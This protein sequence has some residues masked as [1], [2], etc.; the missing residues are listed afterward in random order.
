MKHS[1]RARVIVRVSARNIVLNLI[2]AALKI[3]AG[4]LASSVA[5]LSDG[6][7]SLADV[8]TTLVVLISNRFTSAEKDAEHQYGHEKIESLLTMF[9]AL[10]LCVGAVV[11]AWE[12]VARLIAREQ[13]SFSWFALGA[14]L[15]SAGVKYYLH[16]ATA[17]AARQLDSDAL[18]L[19]AEDYKFDVLLSA[20]VFAGVLLAMLG[21]WFFEPAA[22]LVAAAVL[23]KT[24]AEFFIKAYNQLVDRAADEST[25]NMLREMICA[26]D[27]VEQIDLLMTRRFG[28][29]LYVDL[30]I[31]VDPGL[32]VYEGHEIAQTVHDRL[33]AITDH[34]IK[35]C[36]VHVNPMI[37]ED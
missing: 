26:C 27:G 20:S 7:N 6:L 37:E 10:F 17:R 23:L 32:S 25:V 35:H 2:L 5:V 36:M 18:A 21:L 29:A 11:T 30:E 15:L 13:S 3:V 1:Q 24:A 9:M 31:S 33:E 22:A 12:S 8:A 34:R 14:V 4:A 16:R 19:V 28:N